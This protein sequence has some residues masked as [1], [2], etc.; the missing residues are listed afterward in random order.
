MVIMT[1]NRWKMLSHP[2]HSKA[3]IYAP[4]L[5]IGTPFTQQIL[6][7]NTT[8]T[9]SILDSVI[10]ML[11]QHLQPLLLSLALL[12]LETT[13]KPVSPHPRAVSTKPRSNI[14]PIDRRSRL[15]S[16][17]DGDDL[18]I[19]DVG[20]AQLIQDELR[21][22]RNKYASAM[23]YLGGVQ[24]AEADVSLEPEAV[25]LALPSGLAATSS[26]ASSV[27]VTLGA[28]STAATAYKSTS[29]TMP[30]SLSVPSAVVPSTSIAST[31]ASPSSA[32]SASSFSSLP[33]PSS[34]ASEAVPTLS[35]PSISDKS[36]NTLEAR[37]ASGS[38]GLIDY[39]SGSMDVLYYGYL[40]IG[41]PAQSLS[42]DFDTGSADLWVSFF[43][44]FQS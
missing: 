24:L 36:I 28:P 41:T 32:S 26:S 33:S 30:S 2:Y 15:H 40:S 27:V 7:S 19:F 31:L 16:R 23:R 10:I 4:L 17:D 21:G 8:A 29:S 11:T 43:L 39:I 42:V 13:A 3:Y 5:N 14:I 9:Q 22:V 1:R 35:L 38:L 20:Q 25:P 37:S 6:T 12:S 18:P 44:H 34:P